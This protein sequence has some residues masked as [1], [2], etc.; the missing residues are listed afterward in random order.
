[1]KHKKPVQQGYS[2]C[3]AKTVRTTT[4]LYKFVTYH[5]FIN[6][7]TLSRGVGRKYFRSRALWCL[8]VWTNIFFL[9]WLLQRMLKRKR[10]VSNASKQ[11]NLTSLQAYDCNHLK[12]LL[13]F[14][15]LL[16]ELLKLCLPL[17]VKLCHQVCLECLS[18]GSLQFHHFF[19]FNTLLL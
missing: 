13:L 7:R 5:C 9:V 1:M 17:W 3:E 8:H 14:F 16:G 4:D 18:W 15:H 19:P 12:C 10:T 11:L 6:S 2:V